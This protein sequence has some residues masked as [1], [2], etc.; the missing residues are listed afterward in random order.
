MG[1]AT[2]MLCALLLFLRAETILRFV[3][4][5]RP[6]RTLHQVNHYQPTI[7]RKLFI[8]ARI[9][10]GMTMRIERLPRPLPR[11]F[12]MISNHQ[13]L[14]D[15]PA[16]ALAFPRHAVRFVAKKELGRRIPY[17]SA[18]LRLGQHAL[19]S[20]S[21]NYREGQRELQKFADLS[22]QGICPVVFP[23]GRRSR[24]GKVYVFYSGAVRIILERCMLPVLSV[25][26]D[27]GYRISTLPKLMMNIRGTCYR[28]KPL[29]LYSAPRGKKEIID[30]LGKVE[31]EIVSQ[32]RK[33]RQIENAAPGAL[34]S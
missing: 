17:I 27:G 22:K 5:F 33:W 4:R 31:M 7:S 19:I 1:A 34:R 21:G 14:A 25:A 11:V 28:V 20:R 32:V 18:V 23:E 29:T 12:L 6:G 24:T 15:I 9:L 3:V 26:V 16:L 10:G 30:L 8:L 13:S 2:L